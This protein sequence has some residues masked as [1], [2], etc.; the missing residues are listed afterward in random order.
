[1]PSWEFDAPVPYRAYGRWWFV[2]EGRTRQAHGPYPS[3]GGA[4]AAREA[5][6]R[7]WVDRAAVLGGEALRLRDTVWVVTLPAGHPC[8]GRPF[9]GQAVAGHDPSPAGPPSKEP[10]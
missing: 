2:I 4:L 1:M 9:R 7:R 8:G 3:E 6:F 10:S 5:L